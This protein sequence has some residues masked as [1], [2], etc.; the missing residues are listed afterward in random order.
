[1]MRFS[2]GLRNAILNS[3]GIKEQMANGIIRLYSGAQPASADSAVSGTLLCEYTLDGG[4][5]SHGS[6]TN[7][8]NFDDPVSGVLS[9]AAAEA[10][11]GLGLADGVG[12]YFR[13]CANP[14]DAGGASTTLARI[15]GSVGKSASDLNLSNVNIT[16]GV[17]N[18]I[19]VF[20]ITLDQG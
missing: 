5:F 14:A 12:G 16:V 17:P 10:W 1:M 7:G 3:S 6:A 11:R 2:T 4:A 20:N 19:D 13:F 15:D 9:K 8:I 18:T